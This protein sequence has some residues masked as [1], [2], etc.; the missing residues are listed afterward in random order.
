MVGVVIVVVIVGVLVAAATA[1][2][3]VG[4]DVGSIVAA[5]KSMGV[6]CAMLVSGV[7]EPVAV[8][9]VVACMCKFVKVSIKGRTYVSTGIFIPFLSHH[10]HCR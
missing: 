8:V 9:V 4:V 2:V 1:G 6:A 7:P 10:C 5:A 3:N